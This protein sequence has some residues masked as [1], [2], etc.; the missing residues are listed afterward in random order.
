MGATVDIERYGIVNTA[1]NTIVNA[2]QGESWVRLLSR[3]ATILGVEPRV[4]EVDRVGEDVLLHLFTETS[5]FIPLPNGCLCQVTGEHIH[6]LAQLPQTPSPSLPD[7]AKRKASEVGEVEPRPSKRR[8]LEGS[9][10]KYVFRPRYFPLLDETTGGVPSM[11]HYHA[12][13]YSTPAL[14]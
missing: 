5:V 10:K 6:N 12:C 7:A 1:I 9:K 14:I 2:L 4:D 8:K 13:H 3:F 11:S